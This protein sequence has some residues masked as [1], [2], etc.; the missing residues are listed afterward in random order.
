MFKHLSAPPLSSKY[1]YKCWSQ[2]N[3]NTRRI[4][5]E[6]YKY[7]T[8]TNTNVLR[9]QGSCAPLHPLSPA[10]HDVPFRNVPLHLCISTFVH[11][12]NIRTFQLFKT[13]IFEHFN[14]DVPFCNVPLHLNIC[15]LLKHLNIQTLEHLR[16]FPLTLSLYISSFR[17]L[18]TW[19]LTP[20]SVLENLIVDTFFHQ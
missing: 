1:K 13:G 12:F 5:E 15:T 14:I 16:S 19:T 17:Y 6:K 4:E 18:T 2:E 10:P 9:L 20:P 3:R 7:K 8:N 11:L